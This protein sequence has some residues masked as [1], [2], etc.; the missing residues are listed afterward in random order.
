[1]SGG[2]SPPPDEVRTYTRAWQRAAVTKIRATDENRGDGA[3]VFAG[4][5]IPFQRTA[6]ERP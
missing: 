2:Y 6:S 4:D 5:E 3:V 1:M